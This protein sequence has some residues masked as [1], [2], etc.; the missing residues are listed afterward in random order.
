[1]LLKNSDTQITQ[2]RITLLR[3]VLSQNYSTFQIKIYKP[4]KGVSMGS[5]IS[6][7]VAEIFLQRS[8]DINI[9]KLLDTEN[10]IFYTRYVDDI[11]IIYDTKR[12][13]HDLIN[14]YTWSVRKVSDRI[15]LC[16]HLMDYNLARLHE[17]TLNLSARA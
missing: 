12:T 14:T 3:L 10:I 13:H 17:P 16:E 6:S 15:F 2:Q 11:L 1:M 5:P 4:E 8:E 7:T 9:N